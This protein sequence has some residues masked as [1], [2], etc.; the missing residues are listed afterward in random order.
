MR[1]MRL[2]NMLLSHI[3]R[4][5]GLISQLKTAQPFAFNPEKISPLACATPSIE[6]KPSICAGA[7][8]QM[9]ATSGLVICVV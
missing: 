1:L 4:N 6:P 7:T 3:W 5:S 2:S 8:L 9:A